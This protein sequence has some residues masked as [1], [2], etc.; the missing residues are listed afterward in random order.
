[1]TGIDFLYRRTAASNRTAAVQCGKSDSDN[2]ELV[3]ETPMGRKT[4]VTFRQGRFIMRNSKLKSIVS[5]VLLAAFIVVLT[6]CGR[7]GN[8]QDARTDTRVEDRTE[9]RIDDRKD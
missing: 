6:G 4:L 2:S 7:S 8:R 1:M 3:V 5:L 9:D